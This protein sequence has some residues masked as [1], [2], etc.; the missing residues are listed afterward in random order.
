MIVWFFVWHYYRLALLSGGIIIGW[1][2]GM[3]ECLGYLAGD[4]HSQGIQ[5]QRQGLLPKGG[6][7]SKGASSSR[8]GVAVKGGGVVVKGG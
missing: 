2:G 4:W 7:S 8:G 1:F 5:T 3:S 6:T